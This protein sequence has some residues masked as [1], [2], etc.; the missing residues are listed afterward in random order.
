ME[1]RI[2]KENGVLIKSKR[3]EKKGKTYEE[4]KLDQKGEGKDREQRGKTRIDRHNK[5]ERE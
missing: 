4:D 3:R 5:E 2:Q 1:R